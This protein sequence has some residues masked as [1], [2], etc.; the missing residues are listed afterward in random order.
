MITH[1]IDPVAISLGAIHIRWY[2][3]LFVTGILFSYFVVKHL[4]SKRNLNYGK[5]WL[6]ELL[7]YAVLG[8]L[9][10]ARLGSVV[11]NLDF[12]LSQPLQIIAVW[13]GGLAFHGG[14]IGAVIAGYWYGKK[15]HIPFLK[16]ADL[17]VIPAGVSLAIGRV[18][19]FINSEF[20]GTPTDA[21][22]GVVFTAIDNVARHPVQLYEGLLYI[23][24]SALLWSIKDKVKMDGSLLWLFLILYGIVRFAI[25]FVKVVEPYAFGL[26][27]GQVW[28]I[29]MVLLGAYMLGKTH[30]KLF[31]AKIS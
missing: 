13:N 4:A 17:A 28:S 3:I 15:K 20:Y 29:P 1:T 27:W 31:K 12:Y 19:N 5:D 26:T 23:G 24:I 25:E 22:W 11:S 14:L 16:V 30:S 7:F 8:T 18:G 2:G 6:S 9:I 10:G 21:A